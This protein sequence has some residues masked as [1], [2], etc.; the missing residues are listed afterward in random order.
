M[1]EELISI[2]GPV[3]NVEE[4]LKECIDSI[5]NQTYKRIEII[6]VDDGSTDKSGKICDDYAKIDKRIKVVHKENGGLSDAR[7][8]GISVSSG[9]YIAFV[10]SDDWVEKTMYKKM[11]SLCK[12]YDA[13]ICVCGYFREYKDETI[14]KC[15]S[16][17]VVYKKEDALRELIKGV[18]I[19]DHAW[20]K[21]YKKSLWEHIEYPVGKVYE[22]IRT[23]YRVFQEAGIVCL[24]S[25]RMYHYRQRK[26]SIARDGFTNKKI[27]WLEAIKEMDHDIK[28]NSV[29]YND[30]LYKRVKEVEC[31]LLREYFLY[32]TSKQ[33]KEKYSLAKNL[34]M[35]IRKNR[36]IFLKDKNAMKSFKLI[37]IL[38]CFPMKFTAGIM[39]CKFIKK[40]IEK[41]YVYYA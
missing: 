29:E 37:S 23:T 39:R 18:T 35:D 40:Y 19:Q 1:N 15:S 5:I 7:N 28:E 33:Y 32:S 22:D 25:E 14:S 34:Y 10:D 26:G 21:L 16:K 9:K 17:G 11:Y 3:Y 31:S 30:I 36:N 6:L 2:M 4:Y 8:V 41:K 27:E 38:S 12:K 13:D 20:T 24:L